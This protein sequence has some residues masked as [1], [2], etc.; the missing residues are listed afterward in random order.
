MVGGKTITFT[1]AAALALI[2]AQKSYAQDTYKVKAT[3]A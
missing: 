3:Y 1:I 2:S